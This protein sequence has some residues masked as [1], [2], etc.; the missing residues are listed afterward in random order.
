MGGQEVVTLNSVCGERCS[1]QKTFANRL[2][3]NERVTHVSI[4]GRGVGVGMAKAEDT[5][6]CQGQRVLLES[7]EARTA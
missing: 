1:E 2:E 6:R 5:E 4:W 3:G 7:K